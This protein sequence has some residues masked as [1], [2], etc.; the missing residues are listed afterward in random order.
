MEEK[1]GE[2]RRVL[3]GFPLSSVLSTLVPRRERMVSL[4]Q[5]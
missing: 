3:I 1:A 5:P 2:R 4:M